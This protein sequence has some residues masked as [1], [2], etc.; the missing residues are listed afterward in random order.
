MVEQ[1]S[2][3]VSYHLKYKNDILLEQKIFHLMDQNLDYVNKLC[4][5]YVNLIRKPMHV[6]NLILYFKA[7]IF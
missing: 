6:L 1:I 3:H 2:N 7:I 4:D 5:R